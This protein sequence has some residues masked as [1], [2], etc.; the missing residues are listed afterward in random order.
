MMRGLNE[1]TDQAGN[2]RMCIDCHLSEIG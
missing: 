2:Y 1:A